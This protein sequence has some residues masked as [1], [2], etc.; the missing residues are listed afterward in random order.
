MA[1][2]LFMSLNK[3][4]SHTTKSYPISI[5]CLSTPLLEL[6]FGILGVISDYKVK[7]FN[8]L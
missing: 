4:E 8:K 1:R 5:D 2:K 7:V 6:D 3:D